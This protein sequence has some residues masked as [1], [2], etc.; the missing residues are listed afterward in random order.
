MME[1]QVCSFVLYVDLSGKESMSESKQNCITTLTIDSQRK[2][3][4]K[5][6]P[7]YLDKWEWPAKVECTLFSHYQG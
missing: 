4:T 3:I 1:D 7:F 2:H 5:T 6:T